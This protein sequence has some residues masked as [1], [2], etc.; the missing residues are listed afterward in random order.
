MK[1]LEMFDQQYPEQYQNVAQDN[2][3]PRIGDLRKTKLT[4]KQLNRLRKISDIRHIEHDERLKRIQK[5]YGQ[6]PAAEI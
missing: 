3:Q 4:L 5:Q 2:S 1:L 6:S